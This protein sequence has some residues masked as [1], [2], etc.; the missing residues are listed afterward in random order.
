M[1]SIDRLDWAA[2]I[3]LTAHGARI[4]IRSTRPEAIA[5]LV[6]ALPPVWRPSRNPVVHRMYSLVVAPPDRQRG[7]RHFNVLYADAARIART[8]GMREVLRSLDTDAQLVISELA[9]RLLFVHAGV[10]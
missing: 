9:T 8:E 2:G 5:T 10:V 6:E 3:S 7:R 1:E 4:G